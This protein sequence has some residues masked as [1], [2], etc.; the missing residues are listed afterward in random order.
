[1]E[2]FTKDGWFKTGDLVE[3]MEG[4]YI[5]IIGRANEVV[6]VGGEKVLPAEVESIILQMNEI[7]DVIVYSENSAITGQIVV[8]DVV[9]KG[10]FTSLQAKRV[11]REFCKGKISNYKLPSKVNIVERT[12]YSSRFKKI[13]FM[14]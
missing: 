4:K 3:L 5:K 12:S 6:N 14:N 11:I 13:R 9:I 8:A 2:S 10:N 1:M 7:E